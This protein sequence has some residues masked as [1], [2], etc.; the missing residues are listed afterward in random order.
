MHVGQNLLEALKR[1]LDA[2][3]LKELGLNGST[4]N[5]TASNG[6]GK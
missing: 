4:S 5:G 1:P 6:T 2:S 3:Q